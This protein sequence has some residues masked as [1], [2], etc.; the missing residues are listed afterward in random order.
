VPNPDI[1]AT[2]ATFSRLNDAAIV[3]LWAC[4]PCGSRRRPLQHRCQPRAMR[5]NQQGHRCNRR[6][7]REDGG[8]RD[9][10]W[11]KCKIAP[12]LDVFSLSEISN[13]TG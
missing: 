3:G 9:E 11:F 13:A 7:A 8:Q 12:K 6:R 10:A 2:F 4:T 5:G 1:N